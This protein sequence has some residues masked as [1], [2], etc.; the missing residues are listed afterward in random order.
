M[1]AVHEVS[2]LSPRFTGLWRHPDFVRLWSGA[3]VSHFG[4]LIG[5]IALQLTA[6]LWLDASAAQVS[7]LAAAQLVPGFV[8][9]L[10]AGVWVDRLQRRPIMIAADLG[11]AAALGSIP[12]AAV[13]GVLTIEQLYAVGFV[14]SALSVFFDAA[15][16]A[17]LP[18]L[19]AR[20]DLLE[21]NSKLTASA[22]MAEVMSFSLSGWLVQLLKGPGAVAIDAL[23]FVGS[24]LF[25]SRIRTPEPPP[26]PRE[27]R[28]SAWHEALEGAR[29]V[30]A[31][32]ILRTLAGVAVIHAFA[33][34]IIGVVYLLYLTNE[35]GYQPGVLGIIF[36][37]GGV[38]SLGGAYLA[39]R[40]GV[41]GGLGPALVI[42]NILRS[43]GTALMPLTTSVSWLGTT[44]LIANQ[45]VTDPF[46]AY[47][48]IQDVSLRQTVTPERLQGRMFA[49]VRF[50]EFGARL[51]GTAAGGILG[52]T[53]GLRE[54]L[55]FAVGAM[56]LSTVVLA[57]SPVARL[58]RM[59]SAED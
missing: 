9:G 11:R 32:P 58:R 37:I 18:T 53:I 55:F 52:S 25:L 10:A 43:L 35:V 16:Q 57:L 59:P 29:V 1:F 49:N 44:Y 4:S 41:F 51:I 28:E 6:I 24:A 26:P 30:L 47:Y 13:F 7:L 40:P 34:Q 56:C 3:T 50:L 54:T 15:Y 5:G 17:Y 33:G 19:I 12:V 31:H 22:S 45:C 8:V 21:G 38:T 27:E 2:P 20:D 39:G 14:T 46:W 42:S 36:A 48:E 23:S